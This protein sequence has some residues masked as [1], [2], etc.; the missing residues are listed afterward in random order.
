MTPDI[1][2]HALPLI[3]QITII[4]VVLP[5]LGA[6]ICAITSDRHAAWFTALFTCWAVL[7]TSLLIVW[8]PGVVSYAMGGHKPPVG[9]EYR[10]DSLNRYVLLVISFIAAVTMLYARVSVAKEVDKTKQATFY[11]VFLMCFAGLAGITLTGDIFNIYVFIEISSLAMYA[12]IGMG[13][14]RQ[15]L[16]AALEYLILGTVGATFFLIGVGFLYMM[17]GTLNIADMAERLP[18]VADTRTVEAAFAFIMLGLFMKLAAF[19]LHIWLTN[20]Y[21]QAPSAI[22][23]FVAA[24]GTKVMLYLL[25]RLT[26]SLFGWQFTFESMPMGVVLITLGIVGVLIGSLSAIYQPNIKRLLAF[27]SIAQMGYMLLGFGL[28]TEAGLVA[29]LT[30]L[31]N[32]AVAKAALFM[33]VGCVLYR[34]GGVRIEHFYGV[35]KAMPWTMVA[36][37]LAGLSLIGVPGTAG[38]ISKWY[39]LTALLEAGRVGIAG[40]VLFSSLLAVVYIWKVADAAFFHPQVGKKE[41]REAPLSLLV[42][43]WG[44]VAV[45]FWLG[46]NTHY[47]YDYAATIAQLL[48]GGR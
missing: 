6:A 19:P 32:H 44:M 29:S 22:S 41:L 16:V 24:T 11:A 10:V 21:A 48:M 5:L 9:I 46:F 28:A 36:F 27:S 1:L 25:I 2:H 31:A 34:T 3:E 38:F 26:Y 35:G 13:K 33:A 7:L 15:A 12:L 43:L 4:P 8:E 17:T 39:L 47:T 20:A 40:V 23:V 18:A 30:H 37:V 42:P 14:Q 45:N